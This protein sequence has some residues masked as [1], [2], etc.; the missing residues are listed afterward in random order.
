MGRP[1]NP[2]LAS[3]WQ[4]EGPAGVLGRIRAEHAMQ[5]LPLS[6]GGWVGVLHP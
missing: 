3:P 5:P 1:A 2:H 4:G 6:G